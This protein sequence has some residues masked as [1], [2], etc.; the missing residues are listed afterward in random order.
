MSRYTIPPTPPNLLP[1]TVAYDASDV[2][3]KK[4]KQSIFVYKTINEFDK[5][6]GLTIRGVINGTPGSQP[7]PYGMIP[8]MAEASQSLTVSQYTTLTNNIT[9]EYNRNNTD[10]SGGGGTG[11]LPM[12]IYYISGNNGTTITANAVNSSTAPASVTILGNGSFGSV[13]DTYGPTDFY[14]VFTLPTPIPSN[15][16]IVKFGLNSRS[17]AGDLYVIIGTSGANRL[18]VFTNGD[19]TFTAVAGHTYHMRYVQSTTPA[20]LSLYDATSSTVVVAPRNVPTK[21]TDYYIFLE[22]G[23]T[24]VGSVPN[25]PITITGIDIQPYTP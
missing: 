5:Q 23:N 15:G 18:V 6:H 17:N 11:G 7:V 21:L 10:A 3:S 4:Q 8:S 24:G 25:T 16:G 13:Q 2:I 12:N 22:G 14:F 20:T 19:T 1:R 9:E